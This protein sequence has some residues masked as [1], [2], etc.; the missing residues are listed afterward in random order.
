VAGADATGADLYAADRTILDGFYLL[1]VRIP[2]SAG[3]VIGM[4][5]VV[6]EARTFT[7]YFTYFGHISVPSEFTEAAIYSKYP[8]AM[9]VIFV[10]L[11]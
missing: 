11:L 3:L 10:S 7:A 4:A 1:Q 6:T 5:D 8:S 9:Q 2:R